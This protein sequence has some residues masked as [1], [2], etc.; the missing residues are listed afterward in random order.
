MTGKKG[1]RTFFTASCLTIADMKKQKYSI[2]P[3]LDALDQALNSN[4]AW[5]HFDIYASQSFELNRFLI[6]QLESGFFHLKMVENDLHRGWENFFSITYSK[7]WKDKPIMIPLPGNCW[8]GNKNLSINEISEKKIRDYLIDLL[9]GDNKWMPKRFSGTFFNLPEAEQLVEQ[10]IDPMRPAPNRMVT[11]YSIEP[12]FLFS[13]ED[14][15]KSDYTQLGY[16]DNQGRDC[17]LAI[18]IDDHQKDKHELKLL[19][20][21][22]GN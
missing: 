2:E 1:H 3:L 15:Y 13:M 12:D 11:Y 6:K 9:T 4:T 19:L 8:N 18:L 5:L 7:F 14:Y 21:N 17:V 10:F 16:F 20:T 22:G